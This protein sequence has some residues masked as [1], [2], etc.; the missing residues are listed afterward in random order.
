M[1]DAEL[2]RLAAEKAMGWKCGKVRN[3][4]GLE[5]FFDIHR[6]EGCDM[7]YWPKCTGGDDR[8]WNPIANDADAF[9]LVDKLRMSF[10][11]NLYSGRLSWGCMFRSA[12]GEMFQKTDPNRRK[13]IVLAAISASEAAR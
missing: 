8:S 13:A 2:V 11:L 5:G 4:P 6:D 3:A 1:T 7:V 9:M 10:E 12:Q